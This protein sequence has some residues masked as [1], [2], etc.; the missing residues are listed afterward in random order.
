MKEK[1]KKLCDGYKAYREAAVKKLAKPV[2]LL[3]KIFGWGIMISLFA[4]AMTILGYIFAFIA[5][6]ELAT[7][8]CLAIKSYAIPAVTYSSCS[9]VLFGLVIMYLSGEVALSVKKK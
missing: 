4:G 9:L 8:V 3:K 5:G 7:E 6:G 2:A 1:L